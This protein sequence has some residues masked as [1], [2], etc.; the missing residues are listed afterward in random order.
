MYSLTFSLVPLPCVQDGNQAAVAHE[1]DV[2]A[3]QE[4]RQRRPAG[5]KDQD[6][7]AAIASLEETVKLLATKI[8]LV[9][10]HREFF[11]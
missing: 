2:E 1:K 7:S 9:P 8:K 11:K 6:L 4:I 3:S 10:R 5:D